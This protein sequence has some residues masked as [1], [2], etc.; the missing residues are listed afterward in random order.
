M[1]ALFWAMQHCG[2]YYVHYT[3]SIAV[4]SRTTT[5]FGITIYVLRTELK[6]TTTKSTLRLL[7]IVKQKIETDNFGSKDG[8]MS[9]KGKSGENY[10]N[11]KTKYPQ[12]IKTLSLSF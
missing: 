4:S 8:S 1:T 2:D 9:P 11:T 5:S 6:R 3:E 12:V 7:D 10:R